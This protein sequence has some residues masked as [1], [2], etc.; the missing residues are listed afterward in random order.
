[1]NN[2]T[3]H[4]E[5]A[6]VYVPDGSAALDALRKTT[7]L[8][9]GAHQD[10][11]EI[12][13][14]HGVLECFQRQDRGFTGVVVTNGSGSPRDD[15][16]ADYTDQQ[17]Q[18]VRRIEQKKA[19]V[20]GE[21]RAQAFLDYPSSA[22]KDAANL[23]VAEDIKQLIAAARP[24]VVYTHNL[25]D[26]HDT[27]VAVALRVIGALRDL[28]KDSHPARLIGCE[29]WRGLDWMVDEDKIL[30]D[31]SAHENLSAALLGVHDSQICGGKRYDLA[32]AGRR[33][34]NATFFESHG[35]DASDSLVFGI[36]LTPLLADST[37]DP[38]E[39]VLGYINRFADEVR[40]RISKM[41]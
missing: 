23:N 8:A 22:V 2:L 33:H 28:P 34:A 13:A 27:H 6:E 5:T 7:H 32:A 3:L 37:L 19:A 31:V 26:K 18:Q 40:A 14:C 35:V 20:V 4:T 25:A 12:M 36:D 10:D 30:M 9:V 29:V 17:M 1:M 24:Q 21:Y 16:Y 38:V 41:Q 39:Y 11:I 15:L